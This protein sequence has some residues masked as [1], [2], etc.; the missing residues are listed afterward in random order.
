MDTRKTTGKVI[1][2]IDFTPDTIQ[3]ILPKEFALELVRRY[4][5]AIA[6]IFDP[7]MKV[8]MFG[9]YAKD[10]PNEWSDIDV[11][12]I[13]PKVNREKWWD[14]AVSLGRATRDISSYIEPIL[15]ESGEDTPI[16]REV[17]RT[18]VAV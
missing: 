3:G 18:G 17:M 16:Y 8:M 10:C 7:A 1:D 15:L 6:P 9:S 14:T 5:E 12:V 4:K 11:A 2:P 13:V